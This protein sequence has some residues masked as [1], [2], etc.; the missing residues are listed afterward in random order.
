LV[1]ARQRDVALR[2]RYDAFGVALSSTA[3]IPGLEPVESSTRTH[4]SLCIHIGALPDGLVPALRNADP[5]FPRHATDRARPLTVHALPHGYHFRYDDNTRFLIDRSG[6]TV[7]TAW[8]PPLTDADMATYLLGPIMAFV[9]RLRG[10]LSLHAAVATVRNGAVA[11]CGMAGAGKSTLAAALALR[12]LSIASDDLAPIV[13][14]ADRLRVLPTYPQIRLW[15]AAAT[16]LLGMNHNL[17]QLTPS[18]NKYGF[19]PSRRFDT[20]PRD[21]SAVLILSDRAGGRA[22]RVERLSS[23]TAFVQ[24]LA[25]LHTTY[26][27]PE[28][29]RRGVFTLASRIANDLPVYALIPH[30]DIERIDEACAL[31]EAIGNA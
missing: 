25:H 1:S 18:W 28:Q 4:S 31:I 26:I 17:T 24:L 2:R 27:A 21:L 5:I 12:G 6:R 10:I 16:G 11:I 9:L 30:T 8:E 13:V 7:W 19:T 15:N 3:P 23:R 29:I 22:P 14:G 20:S